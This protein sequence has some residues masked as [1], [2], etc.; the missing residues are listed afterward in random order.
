M[1]NPFRSEADAFRFVWLT[2]GFFA[3]IVIGSLIDRRLGLAVFAVLAA[4][5]L[6]WLFR[7]D[8]FPQPKATPIACEPS[9][10]H[11][12]YPAQSRGA[13]GTDG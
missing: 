8:R 6:W 10:Y 1:K 9:G 11:N 5:A 12:T 3:L 2:I 13:P 4:V 7:R